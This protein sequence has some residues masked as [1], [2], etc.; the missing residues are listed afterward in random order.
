MDQLP[1]A[2]IE[3]LIRQA[4]AERVS[5]SAAV[6][7]GNILEDAAMSISAEAIVLAKHAGRKTVTAED[8][9]LASRS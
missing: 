9:K 4:G 1:K 8:V 6:E 7:L 5:D 2:A 3:R